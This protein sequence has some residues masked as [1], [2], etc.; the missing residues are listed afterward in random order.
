MTEDREPLI[1]YGIWLWAIC[2]MLIIIAFELSQIRDSL[3]IISRAQE[4][5]A[6]PPS[7]E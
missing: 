6:S 1:P 3:V 4:I 2:V 5:I 7:K